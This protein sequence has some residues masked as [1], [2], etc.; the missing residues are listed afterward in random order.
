MEAPIIPHPSR[1][2]PEHPHFEAIVT[3]H[4]AALKAGL[5]MY[6]DPVTGYWVFTSQAHLKRGTCCNSGC[7]HC[8]YLD[9]Q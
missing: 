7:R 8:P 2:N 3:A 6:R 1:L 5:S 4:G 9:E